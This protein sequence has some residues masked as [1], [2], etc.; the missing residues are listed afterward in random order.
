MLHVAGLQA[1][2]DLAEAARRERYTIHGPVNQPGIDEAS[3][4]T[5]KRSERPDE[6]R[7]VALVDIIFVKRKPV[8]QTAA[9]GF[10]L[11]AGFAVLRIGEQ[12][13][14]GDNG[15]GQSRHRQF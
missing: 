10:R 12:N 13:S 4:E 9:C 15:K 11:S 14:D 8:E 1:A 7:V 3:A 6:N 2:P 5:G